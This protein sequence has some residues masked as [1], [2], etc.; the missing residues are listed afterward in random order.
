MSKKI[1]L[2][3][4]SPIP[5]IS[6]I[7]ISLRNIIYNNNININIYILLHDFGIPDSKIEE[8]FNLCP[9]ITEE[10][11][12]EKIEIARLHKN[13]ENVL[14]RAITTNFKEERETEEPEDCE[15]L[16]AKISI[17]EFNKLSENDKQEY[18]QVSKIIQQKPTY[19]FSYSGDFQNIINAKLSEYDM[20]KL[21][22]GKVKSISLEEF[23]NLSAKAKNLFSKICSAPI[24]DIFYILNT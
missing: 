18:K 21:D 20:I 24:T 14:F 22:S 15:V 23:N 1:P 3:S 13:R 12:K 11:L 10:Y 19:K 7:S 2:S 6:S 9:T 4:L 16:P 8:I 17:A 5:P